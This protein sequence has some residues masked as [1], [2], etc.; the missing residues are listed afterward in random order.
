MSVSCSPGDKITWKLVKQLADEIDQLAATKGTP[1][2][3]PLRSIAD[4]PFDQPE[5]KKFKGAVLFYVS[6]PGAQVTS[7]YL[8]NGLQSTVVASLPPSL[9]KMG[10]IDELFLVHEEDGCICTTIFAVDTTTGKPVLKEANASLGCC[11]TL[12]VPQVGDALDASQNLIPG[13]KAQHF[14]TNG[15]PNDQVWEIR[16]ACRNE[17]ALAAFKFDIAGRDEAPMLLATRELEGYF[18]WP[19]K[20]R[21]MDAMIDKLKYILSCANSSGAERDKVR[22][23]TDDPISGH[24]FVPEGCELTICALATDRKLRGLISASNPGCVYE[25]CE[26][27]D[28]I[29]PTYPWDSPTCGGANCG[30]G[31]PKFYCQTLKDLSQ[32]VAAAKNGLKRYSAGKQCRPCSCSFGLE[33]EDH[34]G[35]AESCWPITYF[36]GEVVTLRGFIEERDYL[37]G[38]LD[39][40]GPETCVELD[41][42]NW[43]EGSWDSCNGMLSEDSACGTEPYEPDTHCQDDEDNSWVPAGSFSIPMFGGPP[44]FT[45]LKAA[46]ETAF[47]SCE[48]WLAGGSCSALAATYYGPQ[49]QMPVGLPGLGSAFAVRR[50]FRWRVRLAGTWENCTDTPEAQSVKVVRYT[51]ISGAEPTVVAATITATWDAAEK[52]LVSRWY[53]IEAPEFPAEDLTA[54]EIWVEIVDPSGIPCPRCDIATP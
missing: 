45:A 35:M 4:M 25:D 18:T 33:C 50:S 37:N 9:K 49:F 38:N 39:G 16:G 14:S 34:T 36:D 10:E 27:V 13:A 1:G 51:S 5:V 20:R 40:E 19:I 54:S 28:S 7:Q 43:S 44:N 46:A 26:R 24:A 31:G 47:N 3:A 8:S 23:E 32:I 11:Q 22:K 41:A 2:Y 29:E 42:V 15:A 52:T 12:F 17:D 48:G 6:N 21:Y 53:E 30:T